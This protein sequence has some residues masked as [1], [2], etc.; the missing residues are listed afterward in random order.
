MRTDP[1]LRVREKP[2]R[3]HPLIEGDRRIF[4]DRFHLDGELLLAR[5]AEPELARFDERIF[6]R[7]A[8]PLDA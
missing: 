6:G 5:I 4:H 3:R 7:D 2:K 1:V 8:T